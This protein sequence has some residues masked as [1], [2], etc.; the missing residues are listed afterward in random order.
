LGEYYC[1]RHR[2]RRMRVLRT[3]AEYYTHHLSS[4]LESL[5]VPGQTIVNFE[6]CCCTGWG[7]CNKSCDTCDRRVKFEGRRAI[8]ALLVR[9][10]SDED[11]ITGGVGP[12]MTTAGTTVRFVFGR[13][14]AFEGGV[15]KSS[16]RS[17]RERADSHL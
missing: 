3:Q 9:R 14:R 7:T 17:V 13:S 6:E 12:C 11:V 4:L 2:N 10:L 15:G 16:V 1:G 8:G 5:T